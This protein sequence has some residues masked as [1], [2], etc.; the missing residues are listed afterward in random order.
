MTPTAHLLPVLLGP[1][2]SETI[3]AALDPLGDAQCNTRLIVFV[4]DR[5]LLALFPELVQ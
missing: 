5:I 4:L 2:P 1:N 3:S